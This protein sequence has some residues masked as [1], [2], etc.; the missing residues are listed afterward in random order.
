MSVIEMENAVRF[1]GTVAAVDNLSLTVPKG[2][3]FGLLG[4]NGSGKTT[5]IKLMMGALIPQEGTVRVFGVDPVGMAPETRA[6]IAY[7]AD[8]MALPGWMRLSEAMKLHA[9]Y[10]EQWDSNMA[11]ERLRMYELALN[12]TFGTLSKGQQRRFLLTLALAQLPELLI[13]DEPAAGLDVG[14]RREFLDTL[15]ELANERE[16][17][18]LLSSHILSD[19]ERVVDHVAFTKK[20]RL[21]LQANLEDLKVQVKRLCFTAPPEETALGAHF[22]VL[23]TSHEGGAFQAIV[24]DF[25]AEKLNG[26]N[27]QVEHL[28]L[29]ELFLLYNTPRETEKKT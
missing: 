14:V 20:G 2:S 28:N 17:T 13:L 29:E 8:E 19:V 3:V 23:S 26:W 16:V 11:L 27:C 1:F 7:V 9:S 4:E 24:D 18:I 10:F 22:N 21:V 15:M 6:R 12:Q 25:A 5:S